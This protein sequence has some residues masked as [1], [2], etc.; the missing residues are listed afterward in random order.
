MNKSDSLNNE[1]KIIRFW[2]AIGHDYIN[3]LHDISLRVQLGKQSNEVIY[4]IE[5]LAANL[6]EIRVITTSFRLVDMFQL[7]KILF[8]LVSAGYTIVNNTTISEEK[9]ALQNPDAINHFIDILLDNGS[10]IYSEDKFIE[11]NY[12]SAGNIKLSFPYI[13]KSII[14]SMI[15]NEANIVLQ[16]DKIT[17]AIV[18]II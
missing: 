10:K 3:Y 15:I 13:E 14:I 7:Q 17:G 4:Y 16:E 6:K 9:L 12:T 8:R 2:R 11:V 1:D 18:L 5:E